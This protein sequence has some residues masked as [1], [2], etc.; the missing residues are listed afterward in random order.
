MAQQSRSRPIAMRT[1]AEAGRCIYARFI[2]APRPLV[3][4]LELA[5]ALRVLAANAVELLV[6]RGQGQQLC[7]FPD[8]KIYWGL[9]QTIY[10]GAPYEYVEF[11]D[12][13]HF[14][15]RTPG[16]PL[17]LAVC[18]ATVGERTLAVRLAQA[19][20]GS[21]SVY[22]VYLLAREI[23]GLED[24]ELA[25][26][27]FAAQR[28]SGSLVAAAIAAIN[29]YYVLGSSIL[30]S[31]AIFQLLMLVVLW[32]WAVLWR[33]SVTSF[34]AR[35]WTQYLAAIGCGFMAGAA[36]LVR[37][38][39]G[40]FVLAAL[41]ALAAGRAWEG[42][43]SAAARGTV[44][45]TLGIVLVM[46]PWWARNG[47]IYGKFVPTALWLGASLYD[48]L[49]PNTSG[50]SNMSF[51]ADPVIWPLDELDQDTE[52]MRRAVTFVEEHP[53]Q[54][55]TLAMIKFARYWSPWPNAD[56]LRSPLL[57]VVG[58]VVELPIFALMAIGAWSGRRDP[59][60]VVLLASPLF[61]FCALHLI[62]ASSMRYRMPPEMPALGLTA[63][64]W[65]RLMPRPT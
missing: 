42:R 2:T 10:L 39:W 40:L 50:A 34:I 31:E 17:F 3:L 32:G 25:G 23:G 59:R 62:F 4:V 6:R 26:S 65:N 20:I 55:L 22:V 51:L 53:S 38:S 45:C 35:P 11:T 18:H 14:A 36:L 30:L 1:T 13:P 49:N 9:A 64:A 28:W 21:L 8:T 15:V 48:G 57:A 41:V 27:G 24:R 47:Q 52:L 58:A 5:L 43:A 60:A 33:G 12:I 37:P 46:S 19:I 54:T 7:L 16:Y 61:Y 44:L 63:I 29:P 56:A